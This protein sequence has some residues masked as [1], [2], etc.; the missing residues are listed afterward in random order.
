MMKSRSDV[1]EALVSG[2]DGVMCAELLELSWNN[3]L[4]EGM[5]NRITV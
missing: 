5:A 2:L 4:P 1:Q 3:F